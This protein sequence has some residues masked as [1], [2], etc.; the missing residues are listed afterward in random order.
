MD[1]LAKN[2]AKT[3]EKPVEARL[4]AGFNAPQAN[5]EKRQEIRV[6][7][8]QTRQMPLKNSLLVDNRVINALKDEAVIAAYKVLRTRLLQKMKANRWNALGVTSARSGEGATLSAINIAITLAQELTHSV[9]VVDFNLKNPGIYKTLGL[10]PEYGLENYL[11]DDVPLDQILV[12]P[13]LDRLVVLPC[14]ES[15]PDASE[16][17]TS[18]RVIELVE[19]LKTRYPARI[20]I[21]DL[22]P[23]LEGDEVLSFSS[24]LDALLLVVQ[25]NST[26][27]EDLEMMAE[28]LKGVPIIGTLLN[29]SSR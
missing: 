4:L 17:M 2:T 9:L 21:F 5:A 15:V 6:T 1:N 10:T 27:K 3:V 22:P 13:H 24:C 19:E 26:T 8:S 28:L 18:P 14:K 23:V 7:Y 16:L 20:V 29:K 12:N 11:F 25:E